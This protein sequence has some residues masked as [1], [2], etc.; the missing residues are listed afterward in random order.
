MLRKVLM[1][2]ASSTADRNCEATGEACL[3]TLFPIRQRPDAR[4]ISIKVGISIDVSQFILYQCGRSK[5]TMKGIV[6]YTCR[7]VNS[8]PHSSARCAAKFEAAGLAYLPARSSCGRTFSQDLNPK[9]GTS[10]SNTPYKL[11][12]FKVFPETT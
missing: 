7:C 11:R 6:L 8:T 4:T 3:S 10:Y 9:I 5:V 1:K 12:L 2:L